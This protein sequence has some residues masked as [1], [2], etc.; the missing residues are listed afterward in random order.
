MAVPGL[1]ACYRGS[2]LSYT[3]SCSR[4]QTVTPEI[5][6]KT[7]R[8]QESLYHACGWLHLIWKRSSVRLPCTARAIAHGSP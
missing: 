8:F 2:T 6:Y 5:K 1:R 4:Y 7:A 3:S